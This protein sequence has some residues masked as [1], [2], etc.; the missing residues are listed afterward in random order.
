MMKTKIEE[1]EIGPE[2]K[3]EITKENYDRAI[4]ANSSA[5]LVADAIKEQ[6]PRFSNVKVD[7]ATVRITDKQRGCRYIYLTTPKVAETLLYFDQGWP[8]K[9]FPKKLRIR[10]PVRIL[11]ITRSE[12][13]VK[14]RMAKNATR[15]A[16]LEAKEQ[17]GEV[18]TEKEKASLTKLRNPAP[19]VSRAKSYG[20][21]TVEQVGDDVIVRG[22]VPPKYP[23]RAANLL[24]QRTRHFGAKSAQPS[25]VFQEAVKQA[26][27]AD[28]KKRR[29]S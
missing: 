20:P 12:S 19:K 24:D 16:E 6:Y 8:E 9:V 5:C 27:A 23:K 13:S 3:L 4:T 1:M 14:A 11:P 17:G 2:M 18:L 29:K 21:A 25:E 7:V 28:R 10:N 15:R 22:G 26:V